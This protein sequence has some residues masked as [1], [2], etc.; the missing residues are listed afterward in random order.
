MWHGRLSDGLLIAERTRD[1]A[2]KPR[3]AWGRLVFEDD[4]TGEG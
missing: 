2:A 1:D 3:F 4:V